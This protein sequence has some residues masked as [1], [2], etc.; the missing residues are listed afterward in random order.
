MPPR[1]QPSVDDLIRLVLG[2][3]AEYTAAELAREADVPL[4]QAAQLWRAMGF[5]DVGNA[6]AFTR[7]DIDVVRALMK[8]VDSGQLKFA[9]AV[10]LVRSVG[11][12]TARLS[13]W[14]TDTLG[15]TMLERGVVA[16]A[17]VIAPDEVARVMKETRAL[18]P[19]LQRLMTHAW[20][21]QLA[22]SVARSAAVS[23][24]DADATTGQLSVGFADIVGFTRI[25]RE[26]PDHEL[27]ILVETFDSVSA[28]IV[29][30]TG[31]RLIKTL[32]DEILFVGD[33]AETVAATAVRL[34]AAQ[35][36]IRN[37][38]SRDAQKLR[39]G[40]ATGPVIARM[41]DVFGTTVNRASRLTV[42]AR[43][44]STFIDAETMGALSD[45][46]R[47]VIKGV[48]PRRV[49]G[50]GLMRSWSLQSAPSSQD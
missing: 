11:Q 20:R 46:Q 50:F 5:P 6:R 44:H 37:V 45:D 26:L 18:L 7:A 30:S 19:V 21:R 28:D 38:H 34:H 10:E 48:R 27:A 31:A 16:S 43:P 36:D 42:M 40:I 41:G 33:D 29:A 24:T 3:P 9:E 15:R 25:S 49:R 13:E 35:A 1:K 8:L 14:Q 23:T 4:A 39:V 32:G 2:A 12:T 47:Y 17:D 22:T